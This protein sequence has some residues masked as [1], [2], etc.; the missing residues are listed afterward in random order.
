MSSMLCWEP[1][2]KDVNYCSDELK[3][4]IEKRYELPTVLDEDSLPYLQ[5]LADANIKGAEE[6]IKGINKYNRIYI[7][8]EV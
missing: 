6:L 2:R 1:Y 4:I 8:K 7:R 3:F 5:G